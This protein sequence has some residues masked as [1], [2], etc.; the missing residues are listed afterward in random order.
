[1]FLLT[2]GILALSAFSIVWLKLP[3]RVLSSMILPCLLL[4]IRYLSVSKIAKI[5]QSDRNSNKLSRTIYATILLAVVAPSFFVMAQLHSHAVEMA[6]QERKLNEAMVALSPKPNQL[7]VRWGAS[8]PLGCLGPFSDL[9]TPTRNFKVIPIGAMGQT[10][11]VMSRLKEFGIDDVMRQLDRED[12]YVISH[13]SFNRFIQVYAAEKFGKE[14]VFTPV[15]FN[16]QY[17][18]VFKVKFVEPANLEK[19]KKEWDVGVVANWF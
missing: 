17:F 19:F 13:Q 12:V 2:I 5:F 18:Q 7:Y 15:R 4:G 6:K 3:M 16:P 11:F 10:P 1:M 14:V 9:V 8:L